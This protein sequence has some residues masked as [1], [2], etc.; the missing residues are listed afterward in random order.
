MAFLELGQCSKSPDT[1]DS[2]LL[3]SLGHPVDCR[4]HPSKPVPLSEARLVLFFHLPWRTSKPPEDSLRPSLR[5]RC[6][7]L[8][9]SHTSSRLWE[10]SLFSRGFN[11]LFVLRLGLFPAEV[12]RPTRVA[13]P[14]SQKSRFAPPSAKRIYYCHAAVLHFELLDVSSPFLSPLVQTGAVFPPLIGSARSRSPSRAVS[15]FL[16]SLSLP[17]EIS[18]T[19]AFRSTRF[20]WTGL[21]EHRE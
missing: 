19:A 3:H 21:S 2:R 5:T 8:L 11:S 13:G 15:T 1:Y 9:P 6:V 20:C 4:G 14:D 12:A 7:S 18:R 10:T 16:L 17:F